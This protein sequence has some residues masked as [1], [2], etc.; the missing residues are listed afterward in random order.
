M[1]EKMKKVE[2]YMSLFMGVTLS[3]CLSL[4]GN[5]SS[6]HFTVPGF[7]LSFLASTVISLIIG[8]IVPLRKITLGATKNLQPGSI[9]AKL[10]ET[11]LSDL[12]YTPVITLSMVF[13]AWKSATSHGAKMP[14]LPM[15]VKSLV[16]SLFAAFAIIFIVTPLFMK[17]SMKLA[18]VPAGNGAPPEK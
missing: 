3:F 9:M 5:L 16:I 13:M 17:L 18:G 4:I 7:L 15:F 2:M 6:G 12:I 14:F 11:A 10:T 1:E 8:F